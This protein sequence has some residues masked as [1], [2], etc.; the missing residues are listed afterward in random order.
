[1]RTYTQGQVLR[2]IKRCEKNYPSFVTTPNN[3]S[4]PAKRVMTPDKRDEGDLVDIS[5][6]SKIARDMGLSSNDMGKMCMRRLVELGKKYLPVEGNGLCLYK[7]LLIGLSPFFEG[8]EAFCQ[9]SA[10]DLKH[11]LLLHALDLF[12][13]NWTLFR[14]IMATVVY[15]C[16][17]RN[18]CLSAWFRLMLNPTEWGE[19]YAM[20]P[21][22][23]Q[24]Y[25]IPIRAH[26][27]V[28]RNGYLEMDMITYP[29]LTSA[30]PE[31]FIDVFYNSDN[32]FTP[33]LPVSF[34]GAC[35]SF[36]CLFLRL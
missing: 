20:F 25:G 24:I 7:S 14:C 34:Q 12:E 4:V 22:F 18:S 8:V 21:L 13:E 28:E 35:H 11:Q 1:M 17:V 19:G 15:E 6:L 16:E 27:I 30:E 26:F 29:P 33:A 5:R 32:H 9:F 23:E 3:P 2:K 10:F 31:C 36:F